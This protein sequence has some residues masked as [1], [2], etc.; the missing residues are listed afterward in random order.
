MTSA[1]K[2]QRNS[3]STLDEVELTSTDLTVDSGRIGAIRGS[4][5][6]TEPCQ[7]PDDVAVPGCIVTY[8]DIPSI[9]ATFSCFISFLVY[10]GC[11]GSLGASLPAL[12]AHYNKSEEEFGYAFTARGIGYFFGTIISASLIEMPSKKLPLMPLSCASILLTGISTGILPLVEHYTVILATFVLQGIGAGGI[13]CFCNCVIPEM[14]GARMN[15]WM[16]AMHA[17]FGVGAVIGPTLVGFFGYSN[18]FIAL[19]FLSVLPAILIFSYS[20]F[21]CGNSSSNSTQERPHRESQQPY[22]SLVQTSTIENPLVGSGNV[23]KQ[24]STSVVES[25]NDL[26]SSIIS[27]R[28]PLVIRTVIVLFFVF[29]VGIE[30]AFGGWMPTY[31][32]QVGVVSSRDKAA[33]IVSAYWAALTI[34]RLVAIPLAMVATTTTMMRLQLCLCCTGSLLVYFLAAKSYTVTILVSA[35]FGYA[36]SS[37]FPL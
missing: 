2:L 13:D 37:M 12:A 17:L 11:M 7:Y 27:P 24:I 9:V 35:Y 36:L 22:V 10:G 26:S 8:N 18:T 3:S 34:G 28:A 30:T 20:F 14:W 21:T 15:P 32:L 6:N 25:D 31:A 19:A 4:T 16:Q 33:F 23:E 1:Y 5:S 29:Y